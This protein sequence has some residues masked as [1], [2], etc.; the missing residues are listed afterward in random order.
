[1]ETQQIIEALS[2][3]T[4][5]YLPRLVLAFAILIGGLIVTRLACRTARKTM[6]RR[7]VDESVAGFIVSLLRATLIIIVIISAAGTVG[8]QMTSFVAVIGAAGLAVSLAFQG[9]LSNFAG[10]V[11]ILLFRPFKVGDFIESGSIMGTVVEI[12]I[13]YTI[14]DTFDNKRMVVPN[15]GL[16]NAAVTNYSVN[17]TRRLDLTFGISYDS[18]ITEAKRIIGHVIAQSELTLAEPEPT[19]GVINHAE[20]SIDI[21][22]RVWVNQENYFPAMFE[23]NETVKTEFDKAGI[24][25]P[26]PQ[27]DVNLH[28]R[29]E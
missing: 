8:I 29:A 1:M 6:A 19:V 13:L 5:E 15:G 12:Q 28:R 17:P 21:A 16:A 2:V 11:L 4:A 18:S 14:L 10:G 22:T 23:L 25:I 7:N 3:L 20:S 24:T 26:F 9:S 27:R